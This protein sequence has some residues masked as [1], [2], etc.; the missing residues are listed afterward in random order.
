MVRF[1]YLLLY[2]ILCMQKLLPKPQKTLGGAF[3]FAPLISAIALGCMG[4]HNKK[5]D[6]AFG[7]H[8]CLFFYKYS[9][10]V[11]LQIS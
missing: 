5:K 1:K 2:I 3:F 10:M 7:R 4:L 11:K 8:I 9:S 6:V